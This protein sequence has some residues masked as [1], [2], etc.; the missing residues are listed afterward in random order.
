LKLK[1]LQDRASFRGL[2]ELSVAQLCY[3]ELQLLDLQCVGLCFVLSRSSARLCFL[4]TPLRCG[5]RLALR[6][7]GSARSRKR[8]RERI[9]LA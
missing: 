5:Q 6:R 3:C 9:G 2:P 8:G 4:R 1:L 7:D